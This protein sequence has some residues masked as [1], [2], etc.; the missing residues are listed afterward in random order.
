MKKKINFG[1]FNNY[2]E[3]LSTRY[4]IYKLIMIETQNSLNNLKINERISVGKKK[5]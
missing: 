4:K 2:Y 5:Y 3:Q 1:Y